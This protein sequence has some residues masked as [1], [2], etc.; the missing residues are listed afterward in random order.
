MIGFCFGLIEF[1]NL[2]SL[3]FWSATIPCIYSITLHFMNN[4]PHKYSLRNMFTTNLYIVL[5]I[6]FLM[7]RFATKCCYEVTN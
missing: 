6:M 4:Y 1:V 2:K 3:P 5:H 7:T